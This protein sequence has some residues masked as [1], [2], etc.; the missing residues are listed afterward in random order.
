MMPATSLVTPTRLVVLVPNWM[1]RPSSRAGSWSGCS[2]NLV[3]DTSPRNRV[4]SGLAGSP[5]AISSAMSDSSGLHS[6]AVVNF[7][8]D[9]LA[10]NRSI[11]STPRRKGRQ[12]V[13]QRGGTLMFVRT[14]TGV[15]G[16]CGLGG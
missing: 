10:R 16:A 12:H 4:R 3:S 1:R 15:G 8:S 14:T 11:C 9:S 5:W 13:G 2:M 7:G 6:S